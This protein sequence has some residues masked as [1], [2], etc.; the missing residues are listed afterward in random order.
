MEN[1][2]YKIYKYEQTP[3][4]N[5]DSNII[6]FLITNT[7][8]GKYNNIECTLTFSE[9]NNMTEEEI[10]QMAFT[11]L[12]LQINS[13]VERLKNSDNQVVGKVFLPSN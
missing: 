12:K 10:C 11:K 9:T 3:V 4:P 1:I 5:P 7:D 13:I 8:S 2:E 6:G